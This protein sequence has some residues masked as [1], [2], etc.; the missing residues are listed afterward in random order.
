MGCLALFWHVRVAVDTRALA[1]GPRR[2]RLRLGASLT[3]GE[4]TSH[5]DPNSSYQTKGYGNGLG[6]MLSSRVP[7]ARSATAIWATGPGTAHG[8]RQRPRLTSSRSLRLWP[9]GVAHI[10]NM[11]AFSTAN[12]YA[13]SESEP[14]LDL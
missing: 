9:D 6:V 12:G 7:M 2:G 10:V 14:E 3:T 8:E 11:S 13:V 4:T 1:T 5:N